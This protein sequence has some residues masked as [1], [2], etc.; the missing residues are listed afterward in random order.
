MSTFT[1]RTLR[2]FSILKIEVPSYTAIPDLGIDPEE[3]KKFKTYLHPNDHGSTRY[4]S[5]H[6]EAT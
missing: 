6:K 5:K 4:N 3:N 1:R 2:R